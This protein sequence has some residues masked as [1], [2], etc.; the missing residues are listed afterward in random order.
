MRISLR[1]LKL[2]AVLLLSVTGIAQAQQFDHCGLPPVSSEA[3][4][5]Q[6]ITIPTPDGRI[7]G[8][9]TA[10]EV[11]D[12]KTLVLMLHG[13]GGAR[14]E[15]GGM[16]RRTAHAFAS[17][18]IATLRFDF[19]GSGKSDGKWADTRFSTQ[20]RD[21]V[22]AANALTDTFDASLPVSV[23]GYSQGGLIALRTAA[24]HDLFERVV[25]WAPVLDPLATYGIIFG[26]GTILAAAQTHREH[27]TDDIV[28]GKRLRSGYFAELADADPISDAA[29]VKAPLMIVTGERDPLVKDGRRLAIAASNQR[30]G[31][32][33]LLH[34]DTA[35]H[36]F[37]A[38]RKP[39]LLEHVVACTAKFLLDTNHIQGVKGG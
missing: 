37:G 23:L 16:F 14:N 24:S 6:E 34:E 9:L 31:Q 26:K 30:S 29:M 2:S 4:S 32:T 22:R 5:E 17:Y 8:T 18:G 13:F 33:V 28:E 3:F 27:G 1:I 21:T 35:G 12:P 25:V 15:N 36:D 38:L 20:A 19:I 10:P 39:L 11:G 7:Q